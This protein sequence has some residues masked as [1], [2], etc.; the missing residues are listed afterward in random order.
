MANRHIIQTLSRKVLMAAD[1][2]GS[3]QIHEIIKCSH[4]KE[5]ASFTDKKSHN[6]SYYLSDFL[7]FSTYQPIAAAVVMATQWWSEKNIVL[8]LKKRSA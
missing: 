1:Y 2:K 5:F 6:V 3:L 8:N 7:L 4:N